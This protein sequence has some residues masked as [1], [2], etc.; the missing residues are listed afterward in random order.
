MESEGSGILTGGG[1][2]E[3]GLARETDAGVGAMRRAQS[4]QTELLTVEHTRTH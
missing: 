4:T 1:A 2:G 3:I